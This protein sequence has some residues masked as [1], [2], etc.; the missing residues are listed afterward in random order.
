MVMLLFVLVLSIGAASYFVFEQTIDEGKLGN[1]IQQQQVMKEIK[2]SLLGYANK[3]ISKYGGLPCPDVNGDGKSDIALG[4]GGCA[5]LRGWLPFYDLGLADVRDSAQE[6]FWYSVDP[7][8]VEVDGTAFKDIALSNLVLTLNNVK[9]VAIVIAPQ[10]SI[11]KQ[12]KRVQYD[13]KSYNSEKLINQY[14]EK[15]NKNNN[16]TQFFDDKDGNDFNDVL[17]SIR[18]SEID[19]LLQKNSVYQAYLK[20]L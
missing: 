8:I 14:L 9:S 16:V 17:I 20:D 13:L 15:M 6:R 4:G 1:G 7:L 18:L 2:E 5:Q 10:K 3:N 19:G 12:N 11:G